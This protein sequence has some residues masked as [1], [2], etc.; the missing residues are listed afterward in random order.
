MCGFAKTLGRSQLSDE[1]TVSRVS[2]IKPK[3]TFYLFL[4]VRIA[5]LHTRNFVIIL[6]LKKSSFY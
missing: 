4:A 3:L 2:F 1:I 5:S 6:L